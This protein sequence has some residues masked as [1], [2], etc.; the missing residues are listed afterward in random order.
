MF[1]AED[2]GGLI[3]E[4]LGLFCIWLRRPGHCDF[5]IGV[6]ESPKLAYGILTYCG[7]KSQI[8]LGIRIQE[9]DKELGRQM[10]SDTIVGQPKAKSKI[11]FDSQVSF[12]R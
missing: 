12:Y 10:A 3:E 5:S 9:V 7:L 8:N 11:I 4:F 1:G 6:L 2:V